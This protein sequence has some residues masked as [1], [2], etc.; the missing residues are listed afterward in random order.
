MD[1][2]IDSVTYTCW[3]TP[4]GGIKR[5]LAVTRMADDC[6]WFYVGEGSLPRDLDWVNRQLRKSKW[7][8]SVVVTDISNYYSAIGLW[9]PNARKILEKVTHNDVSNE[10]FPYYSAQWLEIGTAKVYALR[11]SYVG[12]LGWELHIPFDPVSYTHLTLPTILLV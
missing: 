4:S 7:D 2:P 5:D 11:I 8:G 3:L 12:E 9:G 10:A 1:K 6:F